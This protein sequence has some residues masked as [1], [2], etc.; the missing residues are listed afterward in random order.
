MNERFSVRSQIILSI[1]FSLLIVPAILP[2][3]ESQSGCPP[4]QPLSLQFPSWYCWQSNAQVRYSFT[5]ESGSRAFTETEKPLYRG[6][7]AVWNAHRFP[8]NNCSGVFFS[9]SA[10]SNTLEVRKVSDSLNWTTEFTLSPGGFGPKYLIAAVLKVGGTAPYPETDD[11]K[12]VIMIHEI[13]HTFGMDD[14][15]NCTPCSG[16]VMTKC[17]PPAMTLSEER[18]QGNGRHKLW[19]HS[20][21]GWRRAIEGYRHASNGFKYGRIRVQE[22]HK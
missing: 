11:L 14:C 10:G 21:R 13:G 17:N 9:E 2:P 12:K 16:S 15:P 4:V 19:L 18:L 5:N 7:F 22:H 8:G 3:A 1:L 20:L 6:V